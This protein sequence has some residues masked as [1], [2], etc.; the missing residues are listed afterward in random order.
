M[1]DTE[2][3]RDEPAEEVDPY[4]IV[5][6]SF[7][8]DWGEDTIPAA[9]EAAERAKSTTPREEM[10]RCPECGSVRIHNRPGK[11]QPHKRPYAYNCT[12]CWS[13]FDEPDPP[14]A[15]ADG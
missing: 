7:T 10:K 15:E 14:P 1:H 11:S 6:D 9:L 8:D 4:G 12:G 3:M 5:P 13:F 2:T